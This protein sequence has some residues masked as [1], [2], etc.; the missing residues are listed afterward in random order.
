[1]GRVGQRN[2]A[3]HGAV[4]QAALAIGLTQHHGAR[5]AVTRA[6]AFFGAGQFEVIT[7]HR[8]KRA[9]GGDTGQGLRV[10]PV[11][12]AQ[13]WVCRRW[14]VWRAC[15]HARQLTECMTWAYNRIDMN[16]MATLV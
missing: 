12:K 6:A 15:V 2:A 8:Q 1:M 4:E 9:V 14:S 10:A 5:T 16:R 3:V 13:H 7:Q 11:N